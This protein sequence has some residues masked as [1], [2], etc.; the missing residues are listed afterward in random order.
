ML[1]NK[2]KANKI[3]DILITL[4]GASERMKDEFIYH[5]CESKDG[6]DQWWFNG[7]LGYGA[8]YN[9]RTNTIDFDCYLENKTIS[10]KHL[11]KNI[12]LELSKI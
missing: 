3:Y 9:S 6:C 10:Q 8:K 12:N 4:G 1:I 2:E 11:I 5:H 7:K